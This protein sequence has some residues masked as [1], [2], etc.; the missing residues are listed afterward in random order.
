M[1]TIKDKS[2]YDFFNYSMIHSLGLLREAE[3]REVLYLIK[4]PRCSGYGKTVFDEKV[5]KLLNNKLPYGMKFV[6]KCNDCKSIYAG[7]HKLMCRKCGSFNCHHYKD[8]D[9]DGCYKYYY[10]CDECEHVEYIAEGSNSF[11][12]NSYFNEEEYIKNMDDKVRE[13]M[14][15]YT[16][17]PQYSIYYCFDNEQLV[18]D[19]LE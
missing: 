18:K 1:E 2:Y 13:R 4:C 9:R 6:L 14:Y 10:I 3:C 5:V 15:S 7:I 12:W 8:Y 11:G 17:Q 16:N 19:R